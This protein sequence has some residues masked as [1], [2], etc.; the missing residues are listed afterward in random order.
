[1]VDATR[2]FEPGFQVTNAAGTPQSGAVLRFYNA[3]TSNTRTV[4]SDLGLSTSLGV[5]VTTNASGRPAASGGAGAEILIYTG[6]TA[7]KVTAETSAGVS[8]WSFDNVIGALDTS[9]FLTDSITAETPVISKTSD[10]TIVD[11]DQGKIVNS[12]CTGGSFTLTLPSAITVGDG[13][14]ITVRHAGTANN[15][16][17]ATVSSQTING[18]GTSRILYTKDESF[19]LIS[20]GA[21]WHTDGY[22]IA[23][24]TH[25]KFIG[26]TTT[27][28]G[29]PQIMIVPFGQCI[30]AKSGS[31]LLLSPFN[32]NLLTIDSKAEVI[33]DAGVSLAVGAL[34]NSTLYYVYAYM[35]SGTMTLEASAT[36]QAIGTGSGIYTK[37]GDTT[38]TLVGMCYLL[39]GAF[40][41]S[42]TQRYVR[43]WFNDPGVWLR[44]FFTANRSTTSTSITEIDTEIRCEFLTWADDV[45]SLTINGGQSDNAGGVVHTTD[46]GVDG[47]ALDAG[48]TRSSAVTAVIPF[49]LSTF[50]KLAVGYHYATLMGSVASNTGTWTGS[51]T[52]SQR[53]NLNVSIARRS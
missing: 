18:S 30:L 24:L 39:A 44:N 42:S 20:D 16:T 23:T 22:G 13:W 1:M 49:S 48:V 26:R 15:V 46:F 3:G 31:S 19:T 6:T 21:N 45:V 14:R 41:D 28:D 12:N 50:T 10:Y 5:T 52:T 37:N 4:Y 36:A 7:Y 34:S 47:S 8:L 2:V 9:S 38:R 17:V 11:G 35:D 33:P 40:V 29:S 32:G 43:S 51:G 27:G 53:T 25:G